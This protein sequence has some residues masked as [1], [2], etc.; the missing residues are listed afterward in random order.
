VGAEL[1]ELGVAALAVGG[2]AGGVKGW[3]FSGDTP[4][5][6]RERERDRSPA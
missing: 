2:I 5:I 4:T 6:G 1:V 3:F